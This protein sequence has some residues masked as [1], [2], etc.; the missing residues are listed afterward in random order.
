MTEWQI[1]QMAGFRISHPWIAVAPGCKAVP[2]PTRTCGC[3]VFRTTK[4]AQ[5]YIDARMEGEPA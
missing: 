1:V 4:E 5:A 2:H 3:K